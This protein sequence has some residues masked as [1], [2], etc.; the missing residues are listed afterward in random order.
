MQEEAGKEFGPW[1]EGRDGE[2]SS[3]VNKGIEIGSERST[4]KSLWIAAGADESRAR[5]NIGTPDDVCKR[6]A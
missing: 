2:S 1:S 4:L 6:I 5:G 3:S